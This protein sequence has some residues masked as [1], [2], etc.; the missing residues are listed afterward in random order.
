MTHA[1][2]AKIFIPLFLFT[3]LGIMSGCG[4]QAVVDPTPV[5]PPLST[6]EAPAA[7]ITI[8]EG[9]ITE[10]RNLSSQGLVLDALLIY[11]HALNLAE[12]P[13]AGTDAAYKETILKDVD[14]LLSKTAP[15]DIKKFADI[16][17]LTIPGGVF[18]YWMAKN[19]AAQGDFA[20]A[21]MF[22]KAFLE[23]YPNDIRTPEINELLTRM[24]AA[25]FD[26]TKLGCILPLSGKYKL[27]GQ[28][29]MLGIQLALAELTENQGMTVNI[30]VKDS[31]SDPVYAVQCVKELAK[32]NVFAILGPIMVSK[33]AAETAQALE[34]PMMAMTQKT[35][36]PLYGDWI[37]SNFITPEMQVQ[38]LGSYIF[39]RKGLTKVAILYP[40]DRYGIRYMEEF[41]KMA[42]QFNGQVV[43]AEPY[44]GTKTDF[45]GPIVRLTEVQPIDDYGNDEQEG[46]GPDQDIHVTSSRSALQKTNQIDLAFEALFIPDS[47]SRVNLILPQLAYYDARGMLLLGTNLWHRESLLTQARGYNQNAVICDGYFGESTN[48]ETARFDAAFQA[49]FDEKPGFLEAIAYDTTNILFTAV[50]IQDVTSKS[51][52][53]NILSGQMIFDGATGRT[54]FDDTGTPHKD[55]FL[56]TVKSSK[57]R[58]ITN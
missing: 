34:I 15:E 4:K 29:A 57:F 44:D 1:I 2:Q 22:S 14:G 32:D 45:S 13:D 18:D 12:K 21:M 58:E 28:K 6:E 50:K 9:L 26:K 42:E 20:N 36:F 38:A 5:Q 51:D 10:A 56:I 52:L 55:L 54:R 7:K 23:K 30:V 43:A 39:L 25:C 24:Q 16:K 37:F 47:V 35:E 11:N 27:Y 19:F 46:Q 3:A 33:E 17:N 31:R 53:K 41:R 48:P 49:L 8:I 40:A